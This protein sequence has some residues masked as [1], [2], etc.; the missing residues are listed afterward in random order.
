MLPSSNNCKRD[1]KNKTAAAPAASPAPATNQPQCGAVPSREAHPLRHSLPLL[2]AL[3]ANIG[4]PCS[5]TR[6]PCYCWPSRYLPK[7]KSTPTELSRT[8]ICAAHPVFSS[9][10]NLFFLLTAL[11]AATHSGVRACTCTSQQASPGATAVPVPHSTPNSHP[12][13]FGGICRLRPRGVWI[14]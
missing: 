2:R 3:K 10:E 7:H 4:S 6:S 1:N 11:T 5:W 12:S 8:S 13:T 14:P 9:I